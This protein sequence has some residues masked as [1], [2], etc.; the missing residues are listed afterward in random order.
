MSFGELEERPAK[1][2]R[3]FVDDSPVKDST[4]TTEASLPDEIDALPEAAIPTTNS[5]ANGSSK[6]FDAKLFASFVGESV[7]A[8]IVDKLRELSGNNIERGSAY[9]VQYSRTC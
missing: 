5:G 4:F 2:R 6:P 8:S 9:V 1:K 7:L 3:F